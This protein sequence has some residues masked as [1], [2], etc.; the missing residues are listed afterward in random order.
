ML[1][2][3]AAGRPVLVPDRG[4]MACRVRTFGFGTT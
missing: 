4:L 2:A 1:Q 3:L